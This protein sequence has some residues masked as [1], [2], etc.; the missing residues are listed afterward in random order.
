MCGRDYGRRMEGMAD[1]GTLSL[2]SLE[3]PASRQ[4]LEIP[5]LVLMA[6]WRDPGILGLRLP[7]V[8]LRN[9]EAL[10]AWLWN[11]PRVGALK[12]WLWNLRHAE[13]QMEWQSCRY[14]CHRRG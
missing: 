8:C 12:A 5:G 9:V 13:A 1:P 6:D 2:G 10:K 3:D 7:E 11:R 4:D 14:P